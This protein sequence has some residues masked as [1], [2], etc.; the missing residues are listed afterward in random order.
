MNHCEGR[1]GRL[2]RRIAVG[3]LLIVVL[4][5]PASD[6]FFRWRA[7]RSPQWKY[8]EMAMRLDGPNYDL[9]NCV[10]LEARDRKD[11]TRTSWKPLSCI[12]TA[13][14]VYSPEHR[15]GNCANF[16]RDPGRWHFREVAKE[17]AVPGD[18]IIFLKN[19]NYPRH[20]AIYSR[21][22]L[23]GPLCVSTGVPVVGF[24]HVMPIKPVQWFSPFR[25]IRYYRFDRK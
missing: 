12:N 17:D 9:R 4:L 8:A 25:K 18:M 19:G 11:F 24:S 15:C 22:S 3:F 1:G 16:V 2:V 21:D 7:R 14:S 10:D 13:T 20:A 6:M 23:I 5:I